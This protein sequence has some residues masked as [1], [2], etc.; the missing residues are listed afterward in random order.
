MRVEKTHYIKWLFQILTTGTFSQPLFVG[1]M[2]PDIICHS[3]YHV[4]LQKQKWQRLQTALTAVMKQNWMH[5]VVRQLHF[6]QIYGNVVTAATTAHTLT[7]RHI[8]HSLLWHGSSKSLM[9][10][11]QWPTSSLYVTEQGGREGRELLAARQERRDWPNSCVIPPL[12][13][14]LYFSV[15]LSSRHAC[16][17]LMWGDGVQWPGPEISCHSELWLG[18]LQ[19]TRIARPSGWPLGIA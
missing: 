5:H 18:G 4:Y 9:W 15:L 14:L 19:L 16:P 17:A 6:E 10:L 3:C 12:H 2:L 1:L 13:C 11:W 7:D 8:Y